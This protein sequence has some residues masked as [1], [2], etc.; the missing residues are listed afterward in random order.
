M[1]M[2]R[3]SST[4]QD[5]SGSRS[6]PPWLWARCAAG[7]ICCVLWRVGSRGF[8]SLISCCFPEPACLALIYQ[9]TEINRERE[10]PRDWRP[11]NGEGRGAQLRLCRGVRVLLCCCCAVFFIAC[12]GGTA[13]PQHLDSVPK[14]KTPKPPSYLIP[15][16][17]PTFPLLGNT[18]ALQHSPRLQDHLIIRLCGS[19]REGERET[20]AVKGCGSHATASL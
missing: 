16:I 1:S 10:R 12:V 8:W 5:A 4:Y 19:A 15:Q 2:R 13:N 9:G 11:R 3:G 7:L 14:P 20:A 18:A 6:N 17:P